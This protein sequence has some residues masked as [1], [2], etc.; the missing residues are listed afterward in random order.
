MVENTFLVG[1]IDVQKTFGNYASYDFL[2][3]PKNFFCQKHARS[4]Q[5][6][7]ATI[8]TGQ[9]TEACSCR[10]RFNH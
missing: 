9:R 5:S 6:G 2:D 10:T 4:W 7:L 1:Y 3:H 8:E